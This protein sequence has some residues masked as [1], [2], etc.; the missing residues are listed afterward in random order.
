[1]S[2][3]VDIQKEFQGFSLNM[4]L[5]TEDQEV[6]G[7]LGESGSGK[8]MTLRCIAGIVKPDSGRIILNGKTL[9]DS[10]KGINLPPRSRNVGLM[11]QN[12][13]LFPHMTVEQNI[14]AGIREKQRREAQ[15]AK[16]LRLLHLEGLETRRPWQLSGGQQQRVALARM[17]AAEPEILLLDEPFSALDGRLRQEIESDFAKA[18]ETFAGPAILVS[19][20][21]NEIYRYCART[22]IVCD[23]KKVEEGGTKLLFSSPKKIASAKLLCCSNLAKL[24]SSGYVPDWNLHMKPVPAQEG[25]AWVG[26]FGGD[27]ELCAEENGFPVKVVEIAQT[28]HEATVKLEAEGAREPLYATCS[29]MQAEKALRLS[30][31]NGLF[32]KLPESK[33][34]FLHD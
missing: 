6:L 15:I 20:N 21:F 24:D 31:D 28:L 12:Y 16:M 29:K 33:R 3:L 32:A 9:F 7:I 10:E 2:L 26:I 11:F 23:G 5:E 34:F 19:H 22:A 4:Q 17:M 27:I 13:A 18:L 14:A 8:S 30:A 1:M 25:C